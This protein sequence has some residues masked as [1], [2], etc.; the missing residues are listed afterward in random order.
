MYSN[1]YK[2][3]SL[4]INSANIDRIISVWRSG[5]SKESFIINVS[6]ND[7]ANAND[8]GYEGEKAIAEGIMNL[9]LTYLGTTLALLN[10][11]QISLN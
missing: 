3:T 7:I 2:L 4:S 10:P 6:T 1:D 8:I 9:K 5:F 11:L